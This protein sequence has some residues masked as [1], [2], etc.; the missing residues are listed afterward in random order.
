MKTRGFTLV[1]L[2]AVIAIIGVLGALTIVATSRARESARNATCLS[3]LRQIGTG[4]MLY[5]N[6]HHG[7]ITGRAYADEYKSDGTTATYTHWYRKL[8]R[9][10]Y[11]DKSNAYGDS[12][13]FYCPSYTPNAPTDPEVDDPIN[14]YYR[15]GMRN[16]VPN[17][18]GW[19]L[20]DEKRLLPLNAIENPADFFLVADSILISQ[21][22]QAYSIPQGSTDWA[23]HLRHNGNANTVFADG[24]VA[25]MGRDYFAN[26]HLRQFYGGSTNGKPFLLWPAQ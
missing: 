6:D 23:I 21:G 17:E 9:G 10:G 13:V 14:I 4:L 12:P 20:N 22:M 11:V 8:G 18:A 5:A 24:H 16:W 25:S 3:N 15:Y 19:T 7:L 1:E 2:L 26:L